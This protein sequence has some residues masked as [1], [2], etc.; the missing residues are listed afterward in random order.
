VK[1]MLKKRMEEAP[2]FDQVQTQDPAAELGAANVLSTTTD[3][4]YS[5]GLLPLARQAA[6]RLRRCAKKNR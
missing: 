1:T 5:R 2:L 3:I 4:G 6:L